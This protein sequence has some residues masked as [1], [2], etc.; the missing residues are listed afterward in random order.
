MSKPC[1]SQYPI[2]NQNLLRIQRSR[3]MQSMVEEEDEEE[4]KG[5]KEEEAEE[6]EYEI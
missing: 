1:Y 6:E 5:L 4:E 3:K 2:I